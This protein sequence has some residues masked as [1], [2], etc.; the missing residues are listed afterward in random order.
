[1][2]VTVEQS[3]TR[4]ARFARRVREAQV[5]LLFSFP[6]RVFAHVINAG[7]VAAVVWR[8]V[9]Q[10][11]LGIWLIL[12]VAVTLGRYGLA[13][14]FR[15]RP[16]DSDI[17]RWARYFIIGSSA[18][19]ALWGASSFIVWLTPAIADHVFIAFVLA[20]TTSAA[21][22][23]IYPVLRVLYV[24]LA[25]A[26]V[27]LAVNFFLQPGGI[28]I[29]MGLMAVLFIVLMAEQSR[30]ANAT[31]L[32]SLRLQEENRALVADLSAARDNLEA[33]VR[34]RTAELDAAYATLRREMN[35]RLETES[36]L[37]QA[38]KMEAIGQLTGGVAHDFNNL[39]AVI[40]GNAELLAERVNDPATDR[41]LQAV[42]RACARGAQ[43][44]QRLLAFSRK[45]ALQPQAVD[46]NGLIASMMDMLA[47]TLG[48][49]IDI[50]FGPDPDLPPAQVDPGQL[51]N[52]I[53][54]LTLNARDAMPDG[55]ELEI[56]S[57]SISLSGEETGLVVDDAPDAV[58]PGR[59]VMVAVRDSGIG[60][61][62]AQI[63]KVWE[64][65]FTTKRAGEGTGL[66]LSMVY[67]FVRQSEGQVTIDSAVGEGTTVR[68]FLPCAEG[69]A[70]AH[71]QHADITGV[72]TG[73]ECIFVIDDD[74]EIR[75][76]VEKFLSK[77]GYRVVTAA[78]AEDSFEK[79][80]TH[81]KPDLVLS[82]V[83][84]P[85]GN[86]GPGIVA[87]AR[88]RFGPIKAVF[89]SGHATSGF[90]DL[91]GTDES[92]IL[93]HKPFELGHLAR[94]VRRA[95]DGLTD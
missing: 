25:L 30:M 26:G 84:L 61:P 53:L 31:L 48:T 52:A 91:L 5:G 58:P 74:A 42:L 29:A 54:N 41:E 38:Q 64:P 3:V 90:A 47:R 24:Y 77:L 28:Y 36:R 81:G 60:I 66:G 40:A 2:D 44:T 83:L 17:E 67:G 56:T 69:R 46:V 51:E 20:G 86:R 7:L 82:D 35:A 19:A 27:P 92:A 15:R 6:H 63:D 33:R 87:G 34:E 93:I 57:R 11:L 71:A 4:D 89:M 45:Q 59:Y 23:M 73:S 80:A 13:T 18:S 85:G 94:T 62:V 21:A 79:M 95:L 70:P 49:D 65:F 55:G 75:I 43:L 39:L 37:Q 72:P 78:S 68:L 22:M 32:R 9:D 88:K 50:T 8:E 76:M 14:A 1:M 12:S 16:D 10:R